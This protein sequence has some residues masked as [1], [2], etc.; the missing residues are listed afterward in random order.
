MALHRLR[1]QLG[2]NVMSDENW[3]TPDDPARRPVGEDGMAPE[4]WEQVEANLFSGQ[5]IQAIKVIREATGSS[6]KQAKEMAER[7]E[8]MLRQMSPEKFTGK[9]QGCSVSAGV[10]LLSGAAGAWALLS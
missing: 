8:Q 6:L 7:H 10:L 3:K 9:P 2:N 1:G 5:K 4:Q